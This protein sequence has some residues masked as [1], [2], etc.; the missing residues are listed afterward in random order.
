[1]NKVV[2]LTFKIADFVLLNDVLVLVF[3]EWTET[4]LL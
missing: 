2:F 4:S 1:M 3:T